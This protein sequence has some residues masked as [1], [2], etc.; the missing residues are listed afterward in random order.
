MAGKRLRC[1]KRLSLSI[2]ESSSSGSKNQGGEQ[3]C[4][5]SSDMYDPRPREVDGTDIE[6]GIDIGD[7]EKAVVGPDGVSYNRVDK[8]S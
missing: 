2:K 4:R 6:K 3:S 1:F 8:T 5:S 7:A